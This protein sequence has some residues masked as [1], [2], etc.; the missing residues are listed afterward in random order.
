MEQF[1]CKM[2]NQGRIT[3][4]A[5]WRKAHHVKPGA[6]LTVTSEANG[7]HVKTF[8]ESIRE[9]QQIVAKYLGKSTKSLVEELRRER[10]REARLEEREAARYA[11]YFR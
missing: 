1:T 4:P 10:R 3:L 2:D 11:K 7:L 6:E 9:A 8:E 5:S